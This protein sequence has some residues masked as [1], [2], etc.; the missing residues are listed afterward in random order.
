MG[1]GKERAE[2]DEL[3][4]LSGEEEVSENEAGL[5]TDERA[6]ALKRKPAESDPKRKCDRCS[7]M[8]K[9]P[10][11][12]VFERGSKTCTRCAM[13]RKGCRF[14]LSGKGSPKHKMALAS[15]RKEIGELMNS[16]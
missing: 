1:K 13:A 12:C 7:N 4:S 2:Q 9:G 8:K 6:E 3:E 15:K 16:T 11:E 10:V 14:M 5:S